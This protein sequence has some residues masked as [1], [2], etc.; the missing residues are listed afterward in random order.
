[1]NFTEVQLLNSMAM[2]VFPLM[3]ISTMFVSMPVFSTHTI[4]AQIRVILS[5]ALAFIV[6]PLLPQLPQVE[7]MSYEGIMIGIQ[8][9]AIGLTTG[10]IL[11][12]V[13]AAVIFAGQGVAY[14][15]GLGFASMVDPQN[16]QQ[17]PVVAQIYMML[18]TLLFLSLDGHLL[19]IKLLIDSFTSLPI[20]QIFDLNDVWAIITW[21]GRIFSDGLLLTMPVIISLLLVNVVFGVASKS[22]PQLQIFSVGFPITL[23]LGIL[24][25]WITIPDFLELLPDIFDGGYTLIKQLLRLA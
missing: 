6:M 23:M 4:P 18:T 13:F 7:I 21:G 12:M 1:M 15:M 14:G 3:R 10:F 25:M 5:G 11:Q 20:G 22:A 2:F 24:L 9:V 16:G 17:V 19:L 8:Q